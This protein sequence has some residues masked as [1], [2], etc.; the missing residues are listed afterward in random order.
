MAAQ[1]ADI[2]Q[3]LGVTLGAR[4]AVVDD[5]SSFRTESYKERLDWIRS[6]A[7]SRFDALELSLMLVFVALT[8]DVKETAKGF[9]E[10]VT[11]AV[12]RYGGEVNHLDV[13]L[14]TL[15]ESPVVAVGTLS[16]VCE[17]LTRVRN[18]LGFNYFVTPYAAN[19]EALAPI[20]ARLTGT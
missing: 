19:M 9:L 14:Q 4:G 5:L 1:K 12:A 2:V 10:M 17:K 11:G 8:D 6:A 16:E 20:V 15:L 7:C 18:T 13:D 3:V